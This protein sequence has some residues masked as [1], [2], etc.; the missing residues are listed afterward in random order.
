MKYTLSKRKTQELFLKEADHEKNHVVSGPP[1]SSQ[2]RRYQLEQ[3][4]VLWGLNDKEVILDILFNC[5][6]TT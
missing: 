3:Q 2:E 4:P 6:C 5:F 1:F